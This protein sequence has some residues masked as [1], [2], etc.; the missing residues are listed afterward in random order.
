MEEWLQLKFCLLCWNISLNDKGVDIIT[1]DP[2][3]EGRGSPSPRLI[4]FYPDGLYLFCQI[5]SKERHYQTIVIE[6]STIAPTHP[7]TNYQL[8]ILSNT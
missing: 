6:H 5:V 4:A 7:Q 3:H 2:R 1:P 8:I